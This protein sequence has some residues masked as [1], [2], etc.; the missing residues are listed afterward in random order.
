MD[1]HISNRHGTRGKVKVPRSRKP[2]ARTS[3]RNRFAIDRHGHDKGLQEVSK[4]W[5]A[6]DK[7]CHDDDKAWKAAS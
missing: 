6:D 3:I 7:N 5:K 4:A 1:W 2:L